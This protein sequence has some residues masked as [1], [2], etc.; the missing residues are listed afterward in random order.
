VAER[1]SRWWLAMLLLLQL[2]V[3]GVLVPGDWAARVVR[4]EPGLI[5]HHLGPEAGAR[6]LEKGNL[7]FQRWIMEPGIDIAIREFLVPNQEQRDRSTGLQNLG[8]PWFAWVDTRIEILMDVVQQVMNRL[9]LL[10]VWLPF[11]GLILLPAL[12]DGWMSR[13]VKQSSFDYASPILHRFS[14][15]AGL[16]G[17]GLM[18]LCLLA[19]FTLPHTVFPVL[20]CGIA[21]LAGLAVSQ[22]QKR[23]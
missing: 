12:L 2:M 15:V 5:L 10:A 18:I 3:I 16:W 21:M 17:G 13:R 1:G 19:P 11:A 9:A 7:W 20:L 4:E 8:T 22:L 6:V 14:V 23:I